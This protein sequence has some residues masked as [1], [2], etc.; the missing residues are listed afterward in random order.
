M[1]TSDKAFMG[2]DQKLKWLAFSLYPL[3]F[4]LYCPFN[5]HIQQAYQDFNILFYM[6]K[7]DFERK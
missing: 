2:H 7:F 6:G 1:D 3:S 4:F 5:L